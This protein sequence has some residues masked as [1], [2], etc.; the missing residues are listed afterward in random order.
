M[1]FLLCFK[2]LIYVQNK[3][4][5]LFST[6]FV[7][8]KI[9]VNSA[10]SKE[11]ESSIQFV[12]FRCFENTQCTHVPSI[13][14]YFHVSKNTFTDEIKRI[15]LHEL[16]IWLKKFKSRSVWTYRGDDF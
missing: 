4:C 16:S 1:V 12:R 6:I 9:L 15:F 7:I 10:P 3:M 5:A 2:M 14:Y 13:E 8:V 11:I